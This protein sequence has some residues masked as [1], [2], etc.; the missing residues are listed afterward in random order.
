MSNQAPYH[1]LCQPILLN[2][3]GPHP[4]GPRSKPQH[5]APSSFSLHYTTLHN[6]LQLPR[7]PNR[8]LRNLPTRNKHLLLLI[9]PLQV[10][11]IYPPF[12]DNPPSF[13]CK[14]HHAAFRFEEQ[15]IFRVRD[16]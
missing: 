8:I 1:R 4:H 13:L 6:R 11:E 7:I 15:E 2:I 16:R 10:W 3:N 9:Q 5:I 12:P 14:L